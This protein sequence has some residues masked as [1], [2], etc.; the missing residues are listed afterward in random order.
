[1]RMW[2]DSTAPHHLPHLSFMSWCD[3]NQASER[4]I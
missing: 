3:S 1:M 2:D 4:S